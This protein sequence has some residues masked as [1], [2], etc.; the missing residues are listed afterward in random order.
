MLYYLVYFHLNRILRSMRMLWPRINLQLLK[1]LTTEII[2]R[3][4]TP[5][6]MLDNFFRLF[7]Q[8]VLDVIKLDSTRVIRVRKIGFLLGF[9]SAEPYFCRIG[10]DNKIAGINMRRKLRLVLA[11]ENPGNFSSHSA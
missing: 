3:K 5:N 11:S 8:E 4:H 2:V 6:S 9:L 10:N 1:E 7:L